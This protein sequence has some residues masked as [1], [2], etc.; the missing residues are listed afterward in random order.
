MFK[1]TLNNTEVVI[2]AFT[3]NTY[4]TEELIN[5]TGYI[6]VNDADIT[7]PELYELAQ[8]PITSFIIKKDG[9][10][11]YDTGTIDAQITSIDENLIEDRVAVNINLR[12][13]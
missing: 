10:T 11:I 13:N 4:F 6:A 1:A 2:T 9:T 12:F 3:R 5:S 8:E 7:I